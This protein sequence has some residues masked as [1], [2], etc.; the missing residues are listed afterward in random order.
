MATVR[1]GISG[2]RYRG[3]RGDF[4]P[5]G[6]VQ[7]E[8]LTYAAK[9]FSSIEINGSF[10]SLQRP[11]SYASWCDQTPVDF[12]FA[13]K[14]GRFITHFKKLVDVDSA[15]ANFFASG[16]L[17]LGPKLG[18]VLWQLPATVT[19]DADRLAAFFAK[20][21]RTTL[22]AAELAAHHDDKLGPDR[23]LTWASADLP[24]RHALEGRHRTFGTEEASAL[25]RA[26]DIA[27]VC[28]DAGD[29]W[30]RFDR[31]TADF[32]YVRLHGAEELYVSG[33]SD[34]ALD[35][36][37]AKVRDWSA[38]GADVYVYFD[39]DA[40]VHAPYDALRL[41]DRLGKSPG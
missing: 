26:H 8:E 41:L 10:Y 11:S 27:T 12:E 13:V 32:A 18:P 36:W 3:W 21:P 1:I 34:E 23:A 29:K 4:Y 2:W 28:S 39:N 37:A 14:G 17:A 9:R 40:K 15:L 19:F 31:V 22:A 35:T 20:L 7:R 38:T 33:Y 25:L 6:L 30:P 16:L 5:Q 24:I